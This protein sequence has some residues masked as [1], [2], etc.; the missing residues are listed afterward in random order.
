[1]E[2]P[3]S[4][5]RAEGRVYNAESL[6]D[7]QNQLDDQSSESE[8]LKI[9]VDEYLISSGSNIDLRD[10]VE[11]GP[12]NR[13]HSDYA[14]AGTEVKELSYSSIDDEKKQE[15]IMMDKDMF[16]RSRSENL[17]PK[18]TIEELLNS[19]HGLSETKSRSM[20]SKFSRLMLHFGHEV[21]MAVES[22][23]SNPKR[24]LL[25]KL[26]SKHSDQMERALRFQVKTTFF[27]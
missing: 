1:M 11:Y 3:P 14:Y 6:K 5:G 18:V 21:R 15:E 27:I 24:D 10:S 7:E 19:I 22:S 26:F 25:T 4:Y 8:D 12:P 2:I 16:L 9:Q 23:T 20:K 17:Y 13:L